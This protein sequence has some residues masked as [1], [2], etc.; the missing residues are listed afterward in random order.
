MDSKF[1]CFLLTYCLGYVSF[2]LVIYSLPDLVL[3]WWIIY[4][5]C[6]CVRFLYEIIECVVFKRLLFRDLYIHLVVFRPPNISYGYPLCWYSTVV[7][8]PPL[9]QIRA[10]SVVCELHVL[11]WIVCSYISYVYTITCTYGSTGLPYICQFACVA[12]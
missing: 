6:V 5:F 11:I 8:I 3:Y 9:A 7:V 12:H 10:C 4:C 2:V 1:V